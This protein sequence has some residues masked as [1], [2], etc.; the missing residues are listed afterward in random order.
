MPTNVGHGRESQQ[1]QEHTESWHHVP[2]AGDPHSIHHQPEMLSSYDLRPIRRSVV[3]T[4]LKVLNA[5][6]EVVLDARPS[7]LDQEDQDWNRN[8]SDD[9]DRFETHSAALIAVNSTEQFGKECLS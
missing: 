9:Q 8:R 7:E 4:V 3:R 2:N 5:L 6:V 1:N